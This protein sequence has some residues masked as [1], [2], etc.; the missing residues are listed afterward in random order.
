MH[1]FGDEN[2]FAEPPEKGRAKPDNYHG[3]AYRLT[4]ID[5][6]LRATRAGV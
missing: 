2:C 3:S 5:L 4:G 1:D 6:D